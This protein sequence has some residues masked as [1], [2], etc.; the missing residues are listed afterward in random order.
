MKP[1]FSILTVNQFGKRTLYMLRASGPREA[2]A[3][4]R[5]RAKWS[6]N[7]V[8]ILKIENVSKGVSV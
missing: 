3:A 2:A 8:R 1:L 5:Q 6:R 7:K 4:C